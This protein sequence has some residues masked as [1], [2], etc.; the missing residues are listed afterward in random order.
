MKALAVTV[1]LAVGGGPAERALDAQDRPR[2]EKLAAEAHE[3]AGHQQTDHAAQVESARRHSLLAQLAIELGDKALGRRAAETGMA[4]ARRAVKLKPGHADS[5]RLLGTL[6]GQIIPANVMAGLKYGR[7]ALEEVNKA[8]E[9]APNSAEARL[10]RGI[11]NYYLPPAFGGG[12][13][14]AIADLQRAVAL[15]PK[16]AEAKMWL[17]VALRKAGRNA[18]ARK[19]LERSLQLNGG[20]KW[21]RQQLEKT[22]AQ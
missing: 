21:A 11:G 18:E 6:C 8:I 1:L 12:V 17:G 16:S 15:G 3:S 5:H 20:R 2:L 10:A 14:H 7:C 4:S 22:P 13:N 9:L 19:A